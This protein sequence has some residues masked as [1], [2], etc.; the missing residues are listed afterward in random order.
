[1]KTE[2]SPRLLCDMLATMQREYEAFQAYGAADH[3]GAGD[4]AASQYLVDFSIRFPAEYWDD[5]LRFL[6]ANK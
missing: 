6:D 3:P 4:G 2:M 5:A 1:M